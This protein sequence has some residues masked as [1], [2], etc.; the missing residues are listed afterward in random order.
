MSWRK[1]GFLGAQSRRCFGTLPAKAK[2]ESQLPKVSTIDNGIIVGSIENYSP[3]THVIVAVG[4]GPRH[5]KAH[6]KGVCHAI[7]ACCNAS[8]A[9]CNTISVTRYLDVAGS[10][11]TMTTTREHTI[12]HLQTT[13]DHRDMGTAI[14][15]QMCTKQAFKPWE[16]DKFRSR[17]WMDLE[18]LKRDTG[19]RVNELIHEA[20]YR[21]SPLSRSI[22]CSPHKVPK[23]NNGMILDFV[24][25]N[26]TVDRMAVLGIGV[27]HD[28]LFD[29][30]TRNFDVSRSKPATPPA[31]LPSNFKGGSDLRQDD[32]SG[33]VVAALVGAGAPKSASESVAFKVL[34]KMLGGTPQSKYSSNVAS[35]RLHAAI[36][37]A[38]P[39]ACLSLSFEAAYS[40]GGLFGFSL[41]TGAD[42]AGDALKAGA[43][44]VARLAAGDFTDED[45]ARAKHRAKADVLMQVESLAAVGES[46]AVGLLESKVIQDPLA[47]VTAIDNVTKDSLIAA[48]K[49]LNPSS[50]TFS[51]VAIGGTSELPYLDDI[52]VG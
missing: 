26:F 9:E 44:E 52:F 47:P 12:Y 8:T 28:D 51:L 25:E 21:Q 18:Y 40:D 34:A 29:D 31:C 16:L 3:I 48:A 32:G 38:V 30:V 35:S 43:A 49:S 13:R 37:K 17:L 46:L 4:A 20:V 10:N 6:E 24:D 27:D 23:I 19:A 36:T 41:A 33:S 2:V 39:A 7:R 45:V 5:E 11:I 14:L 1:V 15:G 22:Y 50:K 42:S